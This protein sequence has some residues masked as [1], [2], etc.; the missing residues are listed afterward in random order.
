MRLKIFKNFL[1]LFFLLSS[2]YSWAF[3]PTE[4]AQEAER[5]YREQNFSGAAEKWEELHRLGYDNAALYYNLSN[6]YWRQGQ[7]GEA[8]LYLLKAQEL[9]PRDSD[10]RYNLNFIRSRLEKSSS[11]FN[12]LLLL[13]KVPFY[14]FSLSLSESL[15]FSAIL[16]VLFF[17]AL[18]F[19][20]FRK[21]SK[22][23]IFVQILACLF[24]F[25]L[26]QGS[27]A[28]Y[29]KKCIHPGIITAPQASLLELPVL[30][31]NVRATLSE[32]A[33][34]SIVKQEGDFFL[35]E[36]AKKDKGWLPKSSVGEI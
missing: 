33:Q 11:E 19:W 30:S 35:V 4:L 34:V 13:E 10:I 23:K 32:A 15:W 20:V 14:K 25:C 1:I 26:L 31:S 9:E 27:M 2:T 8:K 7:T 24:A 18:M 16:S 29:Q 22:F 21:N 5:L 28:Y 3:N 12:P 6:A 36:T 17:T